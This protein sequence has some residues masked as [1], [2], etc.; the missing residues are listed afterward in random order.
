[1]TRITYVIFGLQIVVAGCAES[2]TGRAQR[3]EPMLT[4]AGFRMVP[5]NTPARRLRLSELTP[6]KINY[7]SRNGT[8]SYW[9]SDP[10]VCDCIYV[11]NQ[12]QN[13]AYER[14]KQESAELISGAEQEKYDEYM[15]GP[16]S[17]IFHG[18]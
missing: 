17:Q 5:A 8:L 16:A 7:V 1:M 13:N 9:F 10:Y 3:L 12:Q 2:R 6:L 15:A 14:L 4:Q 11:G 18:Q